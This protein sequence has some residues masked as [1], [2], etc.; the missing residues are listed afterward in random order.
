[1]GTLSVARH[2]SR[3]RPPNTSQCRDTDL[4]CERKDAVNARCLTMLHGRYLSGRGGGGWGGCV[5]R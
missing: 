3:Y 2:V 1:M 4:H 5:D